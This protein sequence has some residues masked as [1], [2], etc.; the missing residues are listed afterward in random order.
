[1]PEKHSPDWNVPDSDATLVE[2]KDEP[3]PHIG[4]QRTL[5]DEQ[6]AEYHRG[7]AKESMRKRRAKDK[8]EKPNEPDEQEIIFIESYCTNG[9]DERIAAREAGYKNAIRGYEVLARPRVAKAVYE[10]MHYQRMGAP[11]IVNKVGQLARADVGRYLRIKQVLKEQDITD[12]ET[13]ETTTVEVGYSEVVVD[14][15]QAL[16]TD[17]TYPLKSVEFYRTG[18]V[19]KITIEDRLEALKM[20][21]GVFGLFGTGNRP[22][23]DGRA[24]FDKARDLGYEPKMVLDEVMKIAAEWKMELPKELI[25]GQFSENTLSNPDTEIEDAEVS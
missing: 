6:R 9:F 21:G 13:G 12:D 3:K 25:E 24:W 19:K 1:M 8:E 5:T 11:E 16:Q 2:V 17:D 7:I 23:D 18:E 14:L 4:R 10:R 15:V 20:I 22:G